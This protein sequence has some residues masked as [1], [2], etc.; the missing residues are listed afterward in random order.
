M[1]FRSVDLDDTH[2]T[3]TVTFRAV[4]SALEIYKTLDALLV[5]LNIY[6]SILCVH[7][8]AHLGQPPTL[9]VHFFRYSSHLVKVAA[10]YEWP[11]VLLYHFAFFARRSGEMLHG[12]YAGWDKIDVDLME[13]VL[14]QHRKPVTVRRL[15]PC[16]IDRRA[17]MMY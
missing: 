9:P 8:M 1:L 3:A 7:A 10:Q 17:D 12:N 14:V 15:R 11:A 13:E 6:F 16:G 5:P 4:P 2:P